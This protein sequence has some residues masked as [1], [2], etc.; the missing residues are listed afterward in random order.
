MHNNKLD[1]GTFW[2]KAS[3]FFWIIVY[4][5]LVCCSLD[6]IFFWDTV[7][8]ASKQAHHFYEGSMF[9][10]LL[11]D[12]IDSG[13]LPF[14]GWMM[15]WVWKIFGKTLLISH[16]A[17]IPWLVLLIYQ[18]HLFAD[19]IVG[20]TWIPVIVGLILLDPTLMAQGSLISPDIILMGGFF[21]TL[22]GIWAKQKSSVFSGALLCVLASNRG[23]MVVAALF[24]WQIYL[25]WMD[26]KKDLRTV[27]TDLFPF[28]PAS[29]LFV[30][31]Q[32]YHFWAKGWIG[33]HD[34][35]PWAA[36][37]TSVTGW[38]F[39]KN[40]AIIVWRL[41]DFG[42]WM[43]GLILLIGLLKWW[44][45]I[46]KDGTLKRLFYLVVFLSLFLLPSMVL[47][48][49][50]SGHR[51]LLPIIMGLLLITV[52]MLYRLPIVR[53]QN[54]ALILLGL[55]LLT[56]NFWIYP[57]GVAQGWDASLAHWPYFELRSQ[58]NRYLDQSQISIHE[59]GCSFPNLA[60]RKYLDLSPSSLRHTNKDLHHNSYFLFSN[61][62]NDVSSED[63]L[64][65]ER[66]Y[67]PIHTLEDKG[68]CLILYQRKN[69]STIK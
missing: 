9:H 25:N 48:T 1:L 69:R 47:H 38:Q 49:G 24:V 41:A 14:M 60:E 46:K 30:A 52:R 2:R 64:L 33:Y 51:Y 23:A 53:F 54:V 68:I 57:K 44:P 8:L 66:D 42:R 29:L 21:L 59:V 19:K 15:A 7:Q 3:L 20:K 34:H 28:I 67:K 13:H 12:D 27:L 55:S 39:L 58:M 61:L 40:G 4:I 6:H 45:D 37:F 43:M 10:F 22:N 11:P 32:F 50:L 31:F 56:G 18:V 16:L 62:Y 26:G 17:M 35:S 65:I 36:S 63:F 5:T